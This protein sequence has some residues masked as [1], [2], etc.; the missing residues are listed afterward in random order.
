M[1]PLD[2]LGSIK[3]KLGVLVAVTVAVA[4]VLPLAGSRLGLR[5]SIEAAEGFIE[6]AAL[7]TNERRRVG[8]VR[9]VAEPEGALRS[10]GG[11]IA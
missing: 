7:D 11:R 10:G 3:T 5:R 2:R 4:A 8:D 1:R 9:E 6:E